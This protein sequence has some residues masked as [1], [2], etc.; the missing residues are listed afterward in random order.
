MDINLLAVAS[1]LVVFSSANSCLD[2]AGKEVDWTFTYKMPD[3]YAIAYVDS[4]SPSSASAG[5]T[6]FDRA[7]DDT[8]NPPALIKT[9][10]ALEDDSWI[11]ER[12]NSTRRT[13]SSSSGSNY[14]LYNDEP[15]QGSASS[16]LGEFFRATLF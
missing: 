12:L 14:L 13:G 15:D 4:N 9:L 1:L 6:I 7:L 8:S 11:T 3:G 2:S 5:L 10:L 16:T